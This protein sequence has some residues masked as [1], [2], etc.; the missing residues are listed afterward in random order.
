MFEQLIKI[1]INSFFIFIFLYVIMLISESYGIMNRKFIIISGLIALVYLIYA[2]TKLFSYENFNEKVIKSQDNTLKLDNR[3]TDKFI[4]TK[5]NG[6]KIKIIS[7]GLN[8][9][10]SNGP[11]VTHFIPQRQ[12]IVKRRPAFKIKD[13]KVP[14]DVIDNTMKDI[15][16]IESIKSNEIIN[17]TTDSIIKDD[18]GN[19]ISGGIDISNQPTTTLLFKERQ[20]TFPKRSPLKDGRVPLDISGSIMARNENDEIAINA[21]DNN[22]LSEP[23]VTRSTLQQRNTV[24]RPAFKIRDKKIATDV[25]DNTMKNIKS[26]EVTNNITKNKNFVADNSVENIINE[27]VMTDEN[28]YD[29]YGGFIDANSIHVPLN[30]EYT[31]DD[32]GYNYLP[33]SNWLNI[34]KLGPPRV[35]MCVSSGKRC[36]TQPSLTSGYPINLKEWNESRKVMGSDGIDIE[37]IQNHLNTTKPP[38]EITT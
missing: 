7:N 8:N 15:E 33:P 34:P 11:T 2:I 13:S 29:A 20:N 14:I 5:E 4:E 9:S 26:S 16:S 10:S 21:E 25:I 12:N 27:N 37:Y 35:P 24:R 36:A 38:N 23:T 30:Y 17:N 19:V 28:V 32:Y 6:S 18:L 22:S 1:I 3:I 31:Q